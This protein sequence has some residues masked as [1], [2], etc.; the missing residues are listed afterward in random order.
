MVSRKHVFHDLKPYVCT[1]EACDLKLFADRRTWFEHELQFHWVE[2]CCQFC[3]HAPFES[4]E[5]LE[6]HMQSCHGEC[7]TVEQLPALAEISQQTLNKIPAEACPFCELWEPVLKE[8]NLNSSNGVRFVTPVRYRHHVGAHMEQLAL[9]AIPRSEYDPTGNDDVSSEISAGADSLSH[10][11]GNYNSECQISN[12]DIENPPLHI[13]AYLGKEAEVVHL[14]KNGE[15]V[16][17]KGDTWGCALGAAVIGGHSKVVEV[18]LESGADPEAHCG[19]YNTVLEAAAAGDDRDIEE[20]LQKELRDE[21]DVE[22]SLIKPAYTDLDQSFDGRLQDQM[23]QD[24]QPV[25]RVSEHTSTPMMTSVS[26]S[27]RV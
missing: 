26:A 4:R 21:I 12:Q 5:K 27:I 16:N 23:M 7:F 3:S 6:A 8:S 11:R 14:L 24:I 15:D 9:F 2:W 1:F 13:A 10:D 18:L 17:T 20:I 25:T 19:Q 22:I